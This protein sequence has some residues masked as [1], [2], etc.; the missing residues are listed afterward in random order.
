MFPKAIDLKFGEGTT[1]IVTFRDG[2]VMSYDMARLFKEYPFVR[3]LENRELFLSGKLMGLFSVIWNDNIDI[4]VDTVYY[5]GVQIG[6]VKPAHETSA[7]AVLEA[8][9]NKEMSQVELAARCGI[10]QS[11]ISKIERGIANPT[12]DTLERIAKALD[13]K[14]KI[15]FEE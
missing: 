3:D 8:R 2:K 6:Q 12:V 4:G 11:D 9:C 7:D 5:D 15:S 1:I 14:L 13:L 10:D